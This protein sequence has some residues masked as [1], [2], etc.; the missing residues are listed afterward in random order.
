MNAK[1]WLYFSCKNEYGTTAYTVELPALINTVRSVS[2]GEKK[3]NRSS[4][5]M[6][7]AVIEY[8]DVYTMD[9]LFVKRISSLFNMEEELGNGQYILKIKRENSMTLEDKKIIIL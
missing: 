4:M 2:F 6:P 8:A 5:Q 9:G 3:E 1:T 7:G